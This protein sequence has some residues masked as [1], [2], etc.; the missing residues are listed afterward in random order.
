MRIAFDIGGVLSKYPKI[1][2]SMIK[3]FDRNN[4]RTRKDSYLYIEMFIITDMHNLSEIKE[5]LQLNDLYQYIPEG[6]VYSADFEKYGEACKAVLL[7][8]LKMDLF[9]DDFPAYV[10]EGDETCRCLVMPNLKKPY[11][12]DDWKTPNSVGDF[13]RRK[14]VDNFLKGE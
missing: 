10:S 4:Y 14:R 3:A 1:F 5:A 11:Y 2:M 9:F 6:N 8:Q 13:G 12:D 7:K